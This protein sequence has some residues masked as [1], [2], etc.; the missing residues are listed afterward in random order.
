VATA[1]PPESSITSPSGLV[2]SPY[3]SRHDTTF[4]TAYCDGSV[5]HLGFEV[6]AL[7]VWPQLN[8]R[9]DGQILN[10]PW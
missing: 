2:A 1:S 10:L 3:R 4:G 9:N 5:R 6:D 8:S 7:T